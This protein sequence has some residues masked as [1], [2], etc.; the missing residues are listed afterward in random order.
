MIVWLPNIVSYRHLIPQPNIIRSPSGTLSQHELF[1]TWVII[2][3]HRDKMQVIQWLTGTGERLVV[4]SEDVDENN[5]K[6]GRWRWE[7]KGEVPE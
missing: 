7:S 3:Y 4:E 5:R 1:L 6:R 2:I